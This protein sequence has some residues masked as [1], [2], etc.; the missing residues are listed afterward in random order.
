MINK[1]PDKIKDLM[2]WEDFSGLC[3]KHPRTQDGL[4]LPEYE[5]DKSGKGIFKFEEGEKT[6]VN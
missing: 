6:Q 5:N 4:D 3:E 2:S 1:T